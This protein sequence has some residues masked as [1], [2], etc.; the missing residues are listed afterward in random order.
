MRILLTGH[1]CAP[2][3]GSEPGMTWNWAVN[4]ARNN[5][6]WFITHAHFRPEIERHMVRE[7]IPR[8]HFTYT[9]RLG[10]WDPLRLPSLRG[11]RFHYV[12][13]LRRVLQLARELDALHDFDVVHH[14]GWSTVSAPPLLGRLGK[15]FVWGPV[16]GGQ[17]TPTALLGCYGR[18]LPAELLR[19]LRVRTPALLPCSS[20]RRI[21]RGGCLLGEP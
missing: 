14:L 3:S 10:W 15:P 6:V 7:P 4:L 16:G 12:F 21:R 17:T 5:D 20:A 8:L 1:G 2:D 13:W 9:G 11:I 19:T 18:E